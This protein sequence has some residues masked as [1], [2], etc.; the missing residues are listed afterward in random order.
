MHSMR[1][2]IRGNWLLSGRIQSVSRVLG[3]KAAR[4][5]D[6]TGTPLFG[7]TFSAV[8][9]QLYFASIA[10]CQ[11]Y[12]CVF[13]AA[14]AAHPRSRSGAVGGRQR[15][16]RY[17]L[18]EL[19]VEWRHNAAG[20]AVEAE[21]L[22]LAQLRERLLARPLC[23]PTRTTVSRQITQFRRNC[24]LRNRGVIGS[25]T[26]STTTTTTT[27]VWKQDVKRQ[28]HAAAEDRRDSPPMA[29]I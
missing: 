14:R 19:F 9:Y 6:K 27:T 18:A 8:I 16:S 25:K 7:P 10:V 3:Q 1:P 21:V 28:Q 12:S 22:P 15:E 5:R 11:S 29:P 20:A 2:K 17:L 26:T 23:T 13:S 24:K 4:V